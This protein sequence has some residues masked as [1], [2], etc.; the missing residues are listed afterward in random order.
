[1]KLAD[2]QK[3]VLDRLCQLHV[4]E[5]VREDIANDAVSLSVDGMGFHVD[6]SGEI[7]DPRPAPPSTPTTTAAYIRGQK[8]RR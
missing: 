6:N 8:K 2:L 3:R 1:M 5:D 7:R 4:P